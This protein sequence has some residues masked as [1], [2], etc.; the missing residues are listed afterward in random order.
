MQNP[1]FSM[2]RTAWKYAN[3]HRKKFIGIYLMF[4]AANLVVATYPI[5]Y[6]WFVSELQKKGTAVIDTAWIY[7]GG[8][9]GLK[10]LEWLFHGPA[11]IMERKLAFSISQNYIDEL[12]NKVLHLNV[13]WHHEHHSGATI[14][15]IRKA[16]EAMRDFF[17]Q[18]FVYLYSFAKFLLSFGAM[19][20]FSPLFGAIGVVLGF[21]T[22]CIIIRFDKPYI[23][24]LREMHAK[25]HHVSSNLV[26]NL[27]N[28]RTV[29]TLKLE[30]SIHGSLM[31][32]I[33]DVFPSFKRNVTI[34]EFKW[35]TAQMMVALI[36]A[37]TL[38]G[39][40][41]QHWTPGAVF[42]IA[43][44]V[45]LIG[46]VN[47]FTSVFN[48][49]AAQYTQIVRYHTEVQN[50][51]ELE[52]AYASQEKVVSSIM[53]QRWSTL[54]IHDLNFTRKQLHKNVKPVGLHN[55]NMQIS[56]GQRIALVGESGSGKSTLLSLLR[57]LHTPNAGAYVTVD[58][59]S[60]ISFE[61]IGD[62]VTL[63]PQEPEIFENTILYNITLGVPYSDAEINEVCDLVHFTD[64]IT[65]LPDGLNT[66][67]QEKGVN[68]SGGQ[69]QRL[70]LARGV[71]AARNSDIILM[72]E[73]TSSVDPR[74]E[75]MIYRSL[76]DA[77]EGKTIISSLHRLHL[78]THF[79]YVYIMKDGSVIDEG[80]FEHLRRYSLVFKEMWEHQLIDEPQD[81]PPLNIAL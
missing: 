27:S 2:L 62:M 13:E 49:I 61:S 23:R 38:F 76:L 71:L 51:K 63:L 69:K 56:K 37:V 66:H 25:E 57:G 72:D 55:F 8:F 65:K 48:D 32:R 80:T 11:R 40:I 68:L 35:F 74:T 45:I 19:L 46:Y 47:Q 29:I 7:A 67:M 53:P 77:F 78:L 75:R 70:A 43:G 3:N 31:K 14:N 22:V 20:Y 81:Y 60:T 10:F 18:G 24:S 6:G 16:Y 79:D 15:K 21:F 30:K 36:Y 34:N 26:D 54:E 59:T 39:Y 17:Q 50:A 64:V 28:I 9:L 42:E 1:Y 4:V 73:P 5:F 12:Y 58:D 41:Y 33:A 52:Q 44:L